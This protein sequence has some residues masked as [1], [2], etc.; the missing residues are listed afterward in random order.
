MS[1][2]VGTRFIVGVNKGWFRWDYDHDLGRNQF[3]GLRLYRNVVP[4]SLKPDPNPEQP[5]IQNLPNEINDSFAQIQSAQQSVQVVRIWAF[6]RFEGLRFN[7]AGLVVGLDSAFLAN[8]VKVLDAAATKG[9]QIYLCLN[10]WSVYDGPSQDLVNSGR[11]QDY[12]ALQATWK[13]MV[14]NLL[15]NSDYLASFIDNALKPLVNSIGSHPALFAIDVMN[16]PELLTDKDPAITFDNWKN[17]VSKCSSAIRQ[18]NTSVKV[19]CGIMRLSTIKSKASALAPS[20][21]FFDYHI[22]NE[23]GALE[24][25][26]ASEFAGK[27]CIIGECGYPIEITQGGNLL[28]KRIAGAQKFL[29]NAQS[30]GYAGCLIW[31]PEDYETAKDGMLQAAKD[32]ADTRPLIRQGAPQPKSGCFIATAAMGSE[33]HPHVQ[34]LRDYRDTVLLKSRYRGSFESLLAFYYRFSPPV[35]EA[36]VRHRFLKI[37]LRYALV[38]PI[39]FAIKTVLP[40]VDAALGIRKDASRMRRG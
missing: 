20:V 3:S 10:S 29:Q 1:L 18:A 22:Y 27:P 26:V 39:V 24:P 30:L 33:I 8:I 31:R 13:S 9:L 25:Y 15:Q 6:E 5:Y 17:Y 37:L 38:Y 4:D 21:D 14:R 12:L 36:M 28:A 32:F 19:S 34:A 23:D 40:A 2:A 16:E 35:A 7:D 11:A